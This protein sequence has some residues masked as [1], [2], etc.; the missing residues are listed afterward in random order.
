M[1]KVLKQYICADIVDH[2]II[3]YLGILSINTFTNKCD[4]IE[5]LDSALW[6][7]RY[8][9]NPRIKNTVDEFEQIFY[10]PTRFKAY[11]KPYLKSYTRVITRNIA[12]KTFIKNTQS[13]KDTGKTLMKIIQP[14]NFTDIKFIS[15]ITYTRILADI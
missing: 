4:L 8:A 5:D 1:N 3:P 13:I 14:S 10:K 15:S 7:Y 12:E 2:C 9:V 11:S 6:K